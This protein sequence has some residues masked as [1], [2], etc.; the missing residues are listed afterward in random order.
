MPERILIL[1]GTT[2]AR[3]AADA[4]VERGHHVITS[5]AGVTR[6]PKLPAGLVRRGG[7][8]GEAGLVAYISAEGINTVIDATH[9]FAT[10]ISMHAHSVAAGAGA[11]LLRLE[12]AAWTKP[13]DGDWRSVQSLADGLSGLASGARVLVTT[14]R[15]N[16][17]V[18]ATRPDLGGVVRMIEPPSGPLP[19]GW[20][21]LLERPPHDLD[22]E[23]ELMR[24]HGITHLVTK[25]SGGAATHAKIAA[26][27]AS[28]AEVLMIERPE[29]PPCPTFSSVAML[30]AAVGRR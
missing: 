8:G 14:G 13:Q 16:L 19:S 22:H 12:R 29:K 17:D 18:L 27:N 9:P 7:F 11:R 30:I 23:T 20:T 6:E 5:L 1:G 21:L 3:E 24:A 28:G 2:G 25:N 15:R 26:A 4:L 10:Q